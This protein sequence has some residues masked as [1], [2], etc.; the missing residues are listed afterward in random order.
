LRIVILGAGVQGTVFAVRLAIAGHQVTLISRPE[1]A[2]ELRQSVATIQDLKTMRICTMVLPVLERL[3]P[4]FAADICL[5]TVRREQIETVLPDLAAATSIPRVVFLMNYANGSDNLLTFAGA[6]RTVL[7]FPGIAGNRESSIIRYLD[8]PQQ[9]TV[10]EKRAQDIVSLFRDAGFPVDAVRDIEAW[11]QRHAVFITAIAGAL[12][13]SDCDALRLAKNLEMVSRF[14]VAVREGWTSQDRKG[15]G[16]APFALRTMMCWVPLRLSAR[17]WSRLLASPYGEIYFG[18]H[19]RQAP[20][21]M[22]SLADDVR[23]FLREG[24]A[25]RL[26]S[27]LASIDAWQLKFHKDSP[28]GIASGWC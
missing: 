22:A 13:E 21:E 2:I 9:H 14:I 8:I 25:A 18:W 28:G 17:Y 12:Y 3:P 23:N 16:P 24:E 7:A 11:L 6:S 10:V 26:R 1:R 4:D 19:T 5:V 20:A 27:L 15:I